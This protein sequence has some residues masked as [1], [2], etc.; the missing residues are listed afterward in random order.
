M[1]INNK[2]KKTK[3]YDFISHS[4]PFH[5]DP[6]NGSRMHTRLG[7]KMRLFLNQAFLISRLFVIHIYT[8]FLS[9]SDIHSVASVLFYCFQYDL[10]LSFGIQFFVVV[11][12]V[13]TNWRERHRFEPRNCTITFHMILA[14]KCVLFSR[15][16]L[17]RDVM[18]F[19]WYLCILWSKFNHSM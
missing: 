16:S 8:H 2:M 9:L 6:S 7:T 5:S 11:F 14:L 1:S 13:E 15:S 19:C 18:H 12:S 4:Q 17:Y 10:R 3:Q